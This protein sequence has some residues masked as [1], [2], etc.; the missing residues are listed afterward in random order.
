MADL[1]CYP[2]EL[3]W[4]GLEGVSEALLQAGGMDFTGVAGQLWD[5]LILSIRNYHFKGLRGGGAEVEVEGSD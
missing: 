2:P 3:S 1:R 4:D 5:A